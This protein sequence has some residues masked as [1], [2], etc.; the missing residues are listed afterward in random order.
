MMIRT[1]RPDLA[2]LRMPYDEE[3]PCMYFWHSHT[4]HFAY[5]ALTEFV[6]L[7]PFVFTEST[8]ATCQSSS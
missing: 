4:R 2:V 5:G 3:D 7:V 8:E 6:W 1:Y